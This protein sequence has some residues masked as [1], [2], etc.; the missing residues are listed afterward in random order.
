[1]IQPRPQSASFNRRFYAVDGDR[2]IIVDPVT[3]TS[4]TWASEVT[5][6]TLPADCQLISFFRGAAYLAATNSDPTI[7]YKSRTLDPLDWDYAA[8]PQV[9]TA[10]AGNNGTVGQPADAITAIF[11]FADDYLVFGMARSIGVLEGDPNYGGQFQIKTRETG[12]VGP[13]AFCFD[14]RGNLYFVGAGGLYL[15]LRGSFDPSPVGPRKLRRQLEE[16]DLSANFVQMEFRASDRTV[17]IYSTP[18]D[19]ITPATCFVLDTRTEGYFSDQ[20]PIAHGPWAIEQINGVLD[21]DRNLIIGGN[22]GYVR[23]PNDDAL[24]DD[25]VAI[26]SHVEIPIPDLGSGG[27]LEYI[28][29]ELQFVLAEGGGRI[30]W[31][32]FTAASP[33]Q[34]RL[35]TVG[36][37]QASG[38][39]DGTGF[40]PPIGLRATGA[41]HKLRLEATGFAADGTTP[42]R[43][44]LER[45]TAMLAATT[46]RR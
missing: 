33:E 36:Q 21:L 15:M 41:A 37:E 7:W 46:R 8:D 1:L 32:W 34:V 6:G 44:A 10:V 13:R 29:Q 14:D 2:D 9:S 39:L 40:K 12:I 35:Q 42:N 4:V 19:G 17:R 38:V 45:V 16:L 5:D 27:L 30:T 18:T 28:A 23:R 26:P 3:L 20:I 25:G 22:D 31:R 24:T 43:W 11:G